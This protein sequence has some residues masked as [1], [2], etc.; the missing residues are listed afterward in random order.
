[1]RLHAH[2]LVH[3]FEAPFRLANRFD[4]KR[5][6]LRRPVEF[7][8]GVDAQPLVAQIKVAHVAQ[9]ELRPKLPQSMTVIVEISIVSSRGQAGEIEFDG[10][11]QRSIARQA[12][13]QV[14]DLQRIAAGLKCY[15]LG[16]PQRNSPRIAVPRKLNLNAVWAAA[17]AGFVGS[18]QKIA[19]FE[20][21]G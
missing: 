6:N 18:L 2:R 21:P 15:A 9:I 3:Q 12:F 1:M 13:Q 8:T 17:N 19:S 16:D 20:A 5:P 7:Q 11:V 14:R 4:R 10:E